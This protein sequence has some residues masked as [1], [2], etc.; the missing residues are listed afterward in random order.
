[1]PSSH[2]LTAVES[3]TRAFEVTARVHVSSPR[4]AE[5]VTSVARHLCP[6]PTSN[7]PV[8]L[9]PPGTSRAQLPGTRVVPATGGSALVPPPPTPLAL[10]NSLPAVNSHN[11]SRCDSGTHS[12]GKAGWDACPLSVCV[13]SLSCTHPLGAHAPPR[14]RASRESRSSCVPRACMWAVNAAVRCP[15][16]CWIQGRGSGLGRGWLSAARGVRGVPS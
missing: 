13:Q 4:T 8:R 2:E 9:H 15:V 3:A 6:A 7:A 10:P 16:N 12:N 14:P 11:P 5:T 1:M